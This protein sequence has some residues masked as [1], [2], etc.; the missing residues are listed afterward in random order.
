MLPGLFPGAEIKLG[1]AVVLMEF[2]GKGQRASE[3]R[4]NKA[5]CSH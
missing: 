2:P 3:A 4:F 1:P 5:F